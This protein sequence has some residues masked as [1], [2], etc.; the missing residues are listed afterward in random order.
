MGGGTEKHVSEL[1]SRL[2]MTGTLG[3][4]LRPNQN[5]QDLVEIAHPQIRD[6]PNLGK[7]DLKHGLPE[8]VEIMR[9]LGLIH[10]HIH[11]LMGYSR[12]CF[13]F[14]P[15]LCRELG[16]SYDFTFHDYMP[17]CPRINMI[18]G[19]GVFCDKG[20]VAECETC[21]RASGSP[22]GD[23]SVGAWR[24]DYE[25]LLRGARR[26][27]VPDIDGQARIS[28]IMPGFNIE[29]R[30]HPERA[31]SYAKQPPLRRS[32]GDC[33]RVAIIGNLAWHKGS[34]QLKLCAEDAMR[35]Q[36]AITY[37]VFGSC[38]PSLDHLP[39]VEILGRYHQ[40]DLK[41]LLAGR[42]C[43]LAFIPSVCPETYCFV[44]SEALTAGLFPVTFDLGAQA[45]RVRALGWGLSLP[46]SFVHEPSK[47]NDALLA[48]DV[49][50]MPEFGTSI[51]DSYAD[52]LRDYYQ[53]PIQPMGSQ[54]HDVDVPI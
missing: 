5:N 1:C 49:T 50:P 51:G 27:Y 45:R 33:L 16:I 3:L 31:H 11:H 47:V 25:H 20:G 36:L 34:E 43:H 7:I 46:F 39:N 53:L 10:V 44:L 18:D 13:Y 35:R 9:E 22:F 48:C 24:L 30:P 29:V 17:V 41:L 42:P 12:A 19:S 52:L 54:L 4:I 2:E 21:I 23:L 40:E 15:Q 32:A 26:V 6:I 8:A 14:L 38:E 37:V 28:R